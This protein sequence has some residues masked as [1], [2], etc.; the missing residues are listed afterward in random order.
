MFYKLTLN[1]SVLML[2]YGLSNK[3]NM[4][5]CSLL[6]HF[7][8]GH[9]F[10]SCNSPQ[11]FMRMGIPHVIFSDQGK[12]FCN[13]LSAELMKALGIKHRLS[14]PYHPQV[15]L[16]GVLLYVRKIPHKRNTI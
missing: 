14:T 3:G 2:T 5:M 16:Y 1:L 12:E 13:E 7:D 10:F 9:H 15:C 6:A 8:S 11:M 4:K